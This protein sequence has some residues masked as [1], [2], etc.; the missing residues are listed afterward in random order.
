MQLNENLVKAKERNENPFY[1]ND[2]NDLAMA[3]DYRK[4]NPYPADIN[5]GWV[6]GGFSQ[7]G[8]FYSKQVVELSGAIKEYKELIGEQN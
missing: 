4:N 1:R 5:K 2:D 8:K 7:D 6:V 3:L